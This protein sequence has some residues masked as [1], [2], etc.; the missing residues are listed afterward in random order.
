MKTN[1]NHKSV[2]GLEEDSKGY[3]PFYNLDYPYEA[4]KL[5]IATILGEPRL[6][7]SAI[8]GQTIEAWR[9][10]DNKKDHL[11]NVNNNYLFNVPSE[12][13]SF[14]DEIGSKASR[15]IKSSEYGHLFY[16][17]GKISLDFIAATLI[18]INNFGKKEPLSKEFEILF[19]QLNEALNATFKEFLFSINLTSKEDSKYVILDPTNIY[20]TIMAAHQSIEKEAHNTD[21]SIILSTL[22][23]SLYMTILGSLLKINS[24]SL[25]DDELLFNSETVETNMGNFLN[26]FINNNSLDIDSKKRFISLVIVFSKMS[27]FYNNIFDDPIVKAINHLG[28]SF[29][30]LEDEIK[31]DLL[32]LTILNQSDL[33]DYTIT[34]ESFL[35]HYTILDSPETY[36]TNLLKTDIASKN[37]LVLGLIHLVNV[38]QFNGGYLGDTDKRIDSLGEILKNINITEGKVVGLYDYLINNIMKD[39]ATE[40]CPTHF[41]IILN[42]AIVFRYLAK[43]YKVSKEISE[44]IYAGLWQADGYLIFLYHEWFFSGRFYKV[45]KAYRTANMKAI[46]QLSIAKAIMEI[47]IYYYIQFAIDLNKDK[48][49]KIYSEIEDLDIREIRLH[50]ITNSLNIY[51]NHIIPLGRN[52]EIYPSILELRKNTMHNVIYINSFFSGYVKEFEKD[53]HSMT[54][55]HQV[56]YD[57][58]YKNLLPP[59]VPYALYGLEAEDHGILVI[60]KHIE[61]SSNKEGILQFLTDMPYDA[62]VVPMASNNILALKL[63]QSISSIAKNNLLQ[64]E[65]DNRFVVL[66]FKVLFPITFAKENY[67]SGYDK[68]F[69]LTNIDSNNVQSV[70]NEINYEHILPH[71]VSE[72]KFNFL[73]RVK[74]NS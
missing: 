25:I 7:F 44:Y 30:N 2:E 45:N 68:P 29:D 33:S 55:I 14:G 57:L 39:P 3:I 27:E 65:Y 13:L 9:I 46:E 40:C 48:F 74:I 6:K 70:S 69:Y 16:M 49:D 67:Y 73:N 37:V 5:I 42:I 8:N 43:N 12:D 63:S 47:D 17:F 53:S 58:V 71:I 61:S 35:Y 15:Y 60:K 10:Q 54:D 19:Y 72:K 18:E 21:I 26:Y 1:I 20:S 41:S 50:G 24:D 23:G 64:N 52:S 59:I 31:V 62:S 36:T 11:F 4:S 66:L 34:F 32:D 51:L 22:Y 56:I 38:T 28:N